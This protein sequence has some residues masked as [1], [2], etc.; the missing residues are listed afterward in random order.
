MEKSQITGITER[1][2]GRT[3]DIIDELKNIKEVGAIYLFGSYARGNI[4]PFSDIDICVVTERNIS[5]E[6][7]E[8]ILSNSSK[9]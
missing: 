5:K 6:V 8:E 9:K 7:E 2:W 3:D 4:K 1:D